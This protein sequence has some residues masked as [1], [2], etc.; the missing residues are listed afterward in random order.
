MKHVKGST[1]LIFTTIFHFCP[2]LIKHRYQ[3]KGYKTEDKVLL[4]N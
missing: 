2:R 3:S 4:K 1:A